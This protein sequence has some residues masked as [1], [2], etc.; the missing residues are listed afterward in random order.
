M[1]LY[2]CDPRDSCQC[3]DFSWPQVTCSGFS[4]SNVIAGSSTAGN[5]CA[6]YR[7][8]HYIHL[9]HHLWPVSRRWGKIWMYCAW[10]HFP[11]LA[12]CPRC[13]KDDIYFKEEQTLVTSRLWGACVPDRLEDSVDDICSLSSWYW[14]PLDDPMVS[15][16]TDKHG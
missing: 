2:S 10:K 11:E 12:S 7:K 14:M 15:I 13:T 1:T 8:Y 16:N 3:F 5:I 6:V 4:A 9:L